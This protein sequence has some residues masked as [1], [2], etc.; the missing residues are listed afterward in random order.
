MAR[1][2]NIKPAFFQNE[3]LV[4]LDYEVRLL[5]IGLWTIADRE[6][7]LENRPKKIKMQLFPADDL[8]IPRA[9]L[10][11]NRFN[12][13]TLYVVDNVEYIQINSFLEHQHPHHKEADSVIPLM[14]EPSKALDKPEANPSDSLLP[15][16]ES[17]LPTKDLSSPKKP[18]SDPVPFAAI[19]DLYHEK[20]PELP[21]VEKLTTKR[22]GYI[23]QRW[24]E[25]LKDLEHWGNYFDYVKQSDFLMGRTPGQDGRKPFRASLE[26]LTN[27]SNYVKVAEENYHG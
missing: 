17:L 6:G 24:I 3:D 10:G 23:R 26:W 14:N 15:I 27:P 21:S 1:A 7:R 12:L 13:I 20:L 9:L 5:F 19:V 11:L 25:D 22:K 4:E 2:R 8:D 16:T 18:V